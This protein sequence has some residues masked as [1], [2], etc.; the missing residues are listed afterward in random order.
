MMASCIS[1]RFVYDACASTRLPVLA[2]LHF[3]APKTSADDF[4]RPPVETKVRVTLEPG[5]SHEKIIIVSIRHGRDPAGQDITVCLSHR[6]DIPM[7]CE[8]KL[9]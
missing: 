7:V 4:V 6:L 3:S 8:K 2:R 9:Q 5:S 1:S